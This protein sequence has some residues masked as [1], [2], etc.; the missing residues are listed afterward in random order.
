MS[1]TVIEIAPS[2][3]CTRLPTDEVVQQRVVRDLDQPGVARAVTGAQHEQASRHEFDP[4]VGEVAGADLRARQVGEDGHRPARLG[5]HRAH[6]RQ[7]AEM[8]V[9]GAVAEVQPDDVD[10]GVDQAAED[11]RA[12]AGRP[13][14]GHDL[15]APAHICLAI[16]E[17]NSC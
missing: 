5:G 9:D 8:F 7:P 14:C 2:P 11:L 3:S 10:T 4:A 17:W 6:P 15:R 13:E 1:T 16:W 12:V